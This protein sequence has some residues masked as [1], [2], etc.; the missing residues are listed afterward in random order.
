[1]AIETIVEAAVRAAAN[2]EHRDARLPPRHDLHPDRRPAQ[3]DRGAGR[4]HRAGRA[5]S[6]AARRD[7]DG[8]DDDDGGRDPGGAAPGARDRAQ[9]D[10][11]GAAVQRVPDVLPRQRGR[12]LRLLLRLLPARGLRPQPRPVHREGLGDQ[13]GGRPAPPRRHGR[14]VRAPRRDRRRLGLL[15]LRAGLAGDVRDEHADPAP[16]GDDRPR[17][18]AAGNSSRSSTRA[19]TRCSRAAASA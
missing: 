18:T 17:E 13:P 10:A 6:D 14:G 16:R 8:Q 5:L 19:T 4:R 9:Q 2:V 3:G 15:H 7:R 12:V 1:M 11:C